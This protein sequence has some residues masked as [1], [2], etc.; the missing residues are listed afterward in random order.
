MTDLVSCT[1]RT[2]RLVSVALQT[3]QRLIPAPIR[4][5]RAEAPRLQ[6]AHTEGSS[7]TG[8]NRVEKDSSHDR[9]R[10][11]LATSGWGTAAGLASVGGWQA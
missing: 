10:P 3:D 11:Q 9:D 8:A 2:R 7:T 4:P 5:C 1:G 6:P